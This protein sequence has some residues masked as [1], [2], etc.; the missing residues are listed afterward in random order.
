MTCGA[1]RIE[2]DRRRAQGCERTAPLS[3]YDLVRLQP[4]AHQVA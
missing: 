4:L 2:D 1:V 3:F